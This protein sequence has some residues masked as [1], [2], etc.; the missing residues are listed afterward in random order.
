MFDLIKS[1]FIWIA[2]ALLILFWLPMMAVVAL[3]DR[4]PSRYRTGKLFRKLGLAITRVNPNWTLSIEGN[5]DID[6]RRPYIMVCNHQSQADIPLISN[7]AW[8]MKW[9]AKKE[10]FDIPVIGWMMR[11]ARDIPVDRKARNRHLSVLKQ[12]R[13]HLGNNVS[14]IFFPEGTRSRRGNLNKFSK[15]AFDLAIREQLPILPLA[16]DGTQQ[17]L[18]KRSWKFGEAPAIRLKVMD[19]VQ[20]EGMN[21]DQSGELADKVRGM[22]LD[23]LA[24]WRKVSAA[25]IDNTVKQEA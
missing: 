3:F 19:P 17:C 15:G 20:T 7:L 21:K 13:K 16:L 9:I 6:D 22:I 4:D 14:V 24:E 10:L 11:M 12:A 8:E 1:V 25:S 18:P 2:I 23:Q 5:T